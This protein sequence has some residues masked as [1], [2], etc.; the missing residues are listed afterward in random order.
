MIPYS[1]NI[2]DLY[3]Y[4]IIDI[5]FSNKTS[6]PNINNTKKYQDIEN[7]IKKIFQAHKII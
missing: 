6:K 2:I 5:K 1:C 3:S 7:I 4:Y